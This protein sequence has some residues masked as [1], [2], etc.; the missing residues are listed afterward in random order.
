[1]TR[2]KKRETRMGVDEAIDMSFPASDPTAT[3]KATLTEPPRR[4]KD[5]QAP[6]I[7][8][9]EVEQVRRGI[10]HEQN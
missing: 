8:K 10:G 1:M 4:P 2:T 5:R 3:G 6:V 9:E 7:S